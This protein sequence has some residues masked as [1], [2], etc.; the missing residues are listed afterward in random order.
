MRHRSAHF[1]LSLAALAALAAATAVWAAARDVQTPVQQLRVVETYPHDPVA[2]T[3]GL[4]I[5]DG[6][7]YESTG[8][9]G[10]S[11]VREVELKTGEVKRIM[12]LDGQIFGEGMTLL[13]GELFVVT[14]QNRVAYVLDPDTFALK[15]TFRYGGEGWGLTDD[16]ERLILSDGSAVLRFLDPKNGDVLARLPVRDGDRPVDTLNELEYVNGE[17]YANIWYSD[18][19]ARISP[20][21]GKVLG[22][23]DASSLRE[24]VDLANPREDVLNGIAYDRDAKKFYM[25]GKRWPK[26]FEVEIVE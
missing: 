15:R 10:R 13:D 12:A 16:G 1:V 20:E 18:R 3:Q 19:I 22:W 2:F 5:R 8:L 23:L 4:V 17:I 26:L 6:K 14:W 25:T 24:E 9:Y 11:S 7:L 21:T